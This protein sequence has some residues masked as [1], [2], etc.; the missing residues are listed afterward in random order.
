MTLNYIIKAHTTYYLRALN[1]YEAKRINNFNSTDEKCTAS[2]SGKKRNYDV[3][4]T[5]NKREILHYTCSCPTRSRDSIICK[6]VIATWLYFLKNGYQS[7]TEYE[8]SML[9]AH[10]E[11]A[12]MKYAINTNREDILKKSLDDLS[13]YINWKLLP[14]RLF[15][16]HGILVCTIESKLYV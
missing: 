10:E 13:E 9:Y 3:N 5:A 11:I 8:I 6:H 16:K 4:I 2:F 14:Q 7:L 1:Y 12:Y 15:E